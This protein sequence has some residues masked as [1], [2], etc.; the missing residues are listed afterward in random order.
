MDLELKDKVIIVTDGSK[1]I[2][3]AISSVLA[4]EGA[5]PFIVGRNKDDIISACTHKIQ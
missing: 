1:G 4:K 3:G 5:I 2:G